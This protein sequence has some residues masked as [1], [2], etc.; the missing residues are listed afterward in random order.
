MVCGDLGARTDC[1]Q[2]ESLQQETIVT[3]GVG[4]IPSTVIP[5][6]EP[7]AHT[8]TKRRC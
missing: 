4:D 8:P 6:N 1:P 5:W 7:G 3:G 2:W